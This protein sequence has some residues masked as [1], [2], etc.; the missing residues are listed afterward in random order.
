MTKRI[1]KTYDQEFKSRAAKLSQEISLECGGKRH[2]VFLA[3]VFPVDGLST[4]GAANYVANMAVIMA[5]HGWKVTVIT[6]SDKNNVFEWE[7]IEIHQIRATKG[8]HNTGRIML[9]HQKFLKNIWRSLWY[10]YEVYKVN[11]EHKVDIVQ[12]VNTY[13]ISLFRLKKIPYIIRMSDYPPLWS[14]LSRQHYDFEACLK[15]KRIDEEIQNIALKRADKIIVPSV[16][17]QKIIDAKINRTPTVIESPVVIDRNKKFSLFE[18]KLMSDQ[19]WLTYGA[20]IYRKSIHILAQIID[21][22]LDRYPDMSYVIIGRD[23]EI[24]YNEE[25]IF[26]SKLLLEHIKE[27][28][29]RRFLFMGEIS[30]RHRLFSIIKHARLCILPTRIDNLP[31]TCLESMALGKIVI[32]SNNT[33]VEQLITDGVNGFLTEIDNGSE[34]L[35]KIAYVMGLG[36]DERKH[37]EDNAKERVRDLTPEKVYQKMMI[38]YEKVMQ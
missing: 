24:L 14:G 13:G 37:I 2:I 35:E 27:K 3:H 5:H 20:L 28:N 18:E 6:E 23:R 7:G 30:D 4:S 34:L 22:L 16:L 36:E 26:V 17:M 29:K 21:T 11:R 12:S 32:S 38:I 25:Y 31:N 10:N 9:T 1:T 33:S 15:T 8:F 19:Y